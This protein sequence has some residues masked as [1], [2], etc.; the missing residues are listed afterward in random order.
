MPVTID[1]FKVI[2]CTAVSRVAGSAW[3]DAD[4]VVAGL[5][6]PV[7]ASTNDGGRTWR[8]VVSNR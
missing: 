8:S 7:T 6:V 2:R 4:F 3:L 5:T 1:G